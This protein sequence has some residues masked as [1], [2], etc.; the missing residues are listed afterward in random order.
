MLDVRFKR[1]DNVIGIKVVILN[2]LVHVKNAL[3]AKWLLIIDYRYRYHSFVI[4]C[5]GRKILILIR[6]KRVTNHGNPN[7]CLFLLISNYSII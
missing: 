3:Q 4:L 2:L 7:S 6:F 1:I 5:F